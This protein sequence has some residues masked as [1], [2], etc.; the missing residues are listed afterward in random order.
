MNPF[1]ALLK[2]P[3]RRP[4]DPMSDDEKRA[5]QEKHFRDSIAARSHVHIMRDD[6][7]ESDPAHAASK[8]V[9]PTPAPTPAPQP[10]KDAA[11]QRS[12]APV[13]LPL[14][15]GQK[16]RRRVKQVVPE[17]KAAANRIRAGAPPVPTSPSAH[18]RPAGEMTFGAAIRVIARDKEVGDVDL[19]ELGE[20]MRVVAAARAEAG[21]ALRPELAAERDNLGQAG[22]G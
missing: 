5:Q 13:F 18:A 12:K 9:R 15:P 11:L 10:V 4:G 8:R 1:E 6:D 21:A 19:Y 2:P 16:R 20:A 14:E 17:A 3:V 7:D 22:H